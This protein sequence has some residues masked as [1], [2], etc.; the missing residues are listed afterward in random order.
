MTLLEL[1]AY[2]RG[3]YRAILDWEINQELSSRVAHRPPE[4]MVVPG[5]LLHFLHGAAA[6]LVFVVGLSWI[7]IVAPLWVLGLGFGVTLWLISLPIAFSVTRLSTK[8]GRPSRSAMVVSLVA[9]LLYGL[10]LGILL[11]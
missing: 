7:A 2:L 10:S 5:L 6:S 3:G 8:T 4:S 9:H 11:T 1:P